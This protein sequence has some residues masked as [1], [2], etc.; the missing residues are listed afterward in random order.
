MD[1]RYVGV[2]R[3]LASRP[4]NAC[5]SMGSDLATGTGKQGKDDEGRAGERAQAGGPRI[6]QPLQGAPAVQL[7]QGQGLSTQN[8]GS[9]ASTPYSAGGRGQAGG[10]R[11]LQPLQGAPA[12]PLSQ[13]RGLRAQGLGS[14]T[15]TLGPTGRGRPT[16]QLQVV[17]PLQGAA[18]IQ[19][20]QVQG[21][22]GQNLGS[23]ADGRSQAGGSGQA[24]QQRAI[25]PLQQVS[26]L[27]TTQGQGQRSQNV[28]SSASGRGQAGE[29][30][31]AGGGVPTKRIAEPK[32]RA[33][34][35]EERAA[36]GLQQGG[37]GTTGGVRRK[38][39]AGRKKQQQAVE[40]TAEEE[41]H[42]G[43]S[44][45]T[46]R[47]KDSPRAEGSP[48]RETAWKVPHAAFELGQALP[49]QTK[50]RRLQENYEAL[51]TE[52][53]PGEMERLRKM[54]HETAARMQ[55]NNRQL[56]ETGQ[57]H[58]DRGRIYAQARQDQGRARDLQ[59][60]I[61]GEDLFTQTD[62]KRTV[63][64]YQQRQDQMKFNSNQAMTD[65]M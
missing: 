21:L 49:Q 15:T 12:I 26:T 61:R 7:S 34:S 30:G 35:P 11:L 24:G 18:E 51:P 33:D 37:Q 17:Q 10:P 19:P 13:G 47:R 62:V 22:R 41:E 31:Q 6:M 9:S 63:K 54:Y 50:T 2:A 5:E 4:P 55:Q 58:P 48:Q 46:P 44:P 45:S 38:P 3:S 8:V 57:Y 60:L 20:S 56:E 42:V 65:F 27:P 25:P 53:S 16:G 23:G 29:K 39:V 14:G 52:W 59:Q 36:G 28:P 64:G 32:S 1:L 43:Q 40:E